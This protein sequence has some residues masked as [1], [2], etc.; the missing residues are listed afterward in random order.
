MPIVSNN[1]NTYQ[2]AKDDGLLYKAAYPS[3]I[4]SQSVCLL[5]SAFYHPRLLS[6]ESTPCCP[7]WWLILPVWNDN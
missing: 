7:E 2:A 4:V 3:V 6:F 1:V 5:L